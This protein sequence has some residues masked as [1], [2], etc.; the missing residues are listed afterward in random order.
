MLSNQGFLLQQE[1]IGNSVTQHS[2]GNKRFKVLLPREP[3]GDQG[4]AQATLRQS[5]GQFSEDDTGATITLDGDALYTISLLADG[6]PM[7]FTLPSWVRTVMVLTTF[8]YLVIT[9]LVLKTS[10]V[11]AMS[12]LMT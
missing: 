4:H 8:I 9:P 3:A 5:M 11:V 6:N 10:G 7:I 12:P 1:S 2:R